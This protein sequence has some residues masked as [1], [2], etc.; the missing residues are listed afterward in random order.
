MKRLLAPAIQVILTLAIAF[1]SCDNNS[2]SLPKEYVG[3]EKSE[4]DLAYKENDEQV[5]MQVKIIAV[6]KS[7]EDRVVLIES[8]QSSQSTIKHFLR[9]K[10]NRITIPAGKKS[11]KAT[12]TVYP[13]NLS[14]LRKL[15]L[16]CRPQTPGAE[17]SKLIIRLVKK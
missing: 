10:E 1:T 9:I 11:A 7:K 12:I 4:C 16:I 15:Q 8:P 2:N 17:A 13:K 5:E 6:D 3:F 14:I